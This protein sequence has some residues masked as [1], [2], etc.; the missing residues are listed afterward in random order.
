MAKFHPSK[1]SRNFT[2]SSCCEILP[3]QV[4][5][6]FHLS[7]LLRNFTPSSCREISP[8]QV[9]AKF[10]PSKLSRNFTPSSCCEITPLQVVA[11]FHVTRSK[12]KKYLFTY[13]ELDQHS[14]EC[15]RASDDKGRYTARLYPA[16]QSSLPPGTS[17]DRGQSCHD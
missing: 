2:P 13:Q 7:K 15:P 9:V 12:L 16:R 6:K 17:P 4:V 10:H 14:A 5:V 3:L 11:K 1:L 8:L